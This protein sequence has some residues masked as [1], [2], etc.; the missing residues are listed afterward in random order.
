MFL[1]IYYFL[2]IHKCYLLFIDKDVSKYFLFIICY[3]LVKMFLNIYYFL[4]IISYFLFLISYL[5]IK[6]FLNI[7]YFLLLIYYLSLNNIYE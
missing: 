4:F 7:Y 1:N 2:F 6:M 3:L 5:L